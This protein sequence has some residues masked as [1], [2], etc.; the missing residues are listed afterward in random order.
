MNYIEQNVDFLKQQIAAQK[1]I[2]KSIDHY[3]PAKLITI[4]GENGA[5]KTNYSAITAPYKRT[6]YINFE[7]SGSADL[8]Q[9]LNE[10]GLIKYKEYN[11]DK[12]PTSFLK[13]ISQFC[14]EVNREKPKIKVLIIDSIGEFVSRHIE[15]EMNGS[16]VE[17]YH[18]D[19]GAFCSSTTIPLLN[20]FYHDIM[21][22]GITIIQLCGINEPNEKDQIV[23]DNLQVQTSVMKEFIKK[24]SNAIYMIDDISKEGKYSLLKDNAGL[25][26]MTLSEFFLS[27]K[28]VINSL[29][30]TP[31]EIT[32]KEDD[33][34]NGRIVTY[35]II[36]ILNIL[37]KK[38]ENL[39]NHYKEQSKNLK[40]I[41][42]SLKEY[43]ENTN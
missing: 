37:V 17:K 21:D 36:S 8:P 5:G 34:K 13:E 9:S 32:Y 42:D 20:K 11:R 24:R 18:W 35:G 1:E 39:Y 12:T 6:L 10:I 38:N 22:L 27:R 4:L 23:S 30:Q 3:C 2:Y 41:E 43:L 28:L 33:S 31:N 25:K 7:S 29:G 14:Q 16:K 40:V 15:K 19:S 26:N